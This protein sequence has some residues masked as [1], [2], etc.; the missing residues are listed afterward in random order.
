M[1]TKEIETLIEQ[2]DDEIKES[3]VERPLSADEIESLTSSHDNIP[4]EYADAF[5]A[6]LQNKNFGQFETLPR[7]LRNY[8]GALEVKAL[9]E[10]FGEDLS[11]EPPEVGEYLEQNVMNAA[12]RAGISAEKNKPETKERAKALDTYM[13]GALMRNTMMPTSAAQ[14]GVLYDYREADEVDRIVEQNNA[15]QV[16]M[17]K[18]MLLAQLGKYDVIEKNGLGGALEVPVYET[19]VHGNRTNFVLPAGADSGQVIDAFMGGEGAKT[20]GL[21]E[22]TAATHYAK[23]RKI[24][25]NG[26]LRSE[27][28]E[29]KTF[30]PFKVFSNQYGMNIA[31]GGVGFKGPDRNVITGSG[32]SGHM[33]MRAEKGDK[34]HCGS[35]L[36]GIEGSEPGKSSYLGNDHGARAKSAK[37]SAF[38]ADKSI[39]GKKT[40]GRQVDLSGIDARDLAELLDTFADKYT[41]LQRNADT[42]EGAD[43]IAAINDMLMGKHMQPEKLIEM[44]G[45]LGMNNEKISDIV[46]QARGGYL[47]KLDAAGITEEEFKQSVRATY[48]QDKACQMA[49]ERFERAGDDLELSVGA[50]K[51]LMLT[52]E[53]RKL[54][55]KIRHPIKN[56]KEYLTI[57][58]LTKKLQKEKEFRP[59]DIVNTFRSNEDTF[60]MNWGEGL[61]YD[62]DTVKFALDNMKAFKVGES[63][64]GEVVKEGAKSVSA[65]A[66]A[67]DEVEQMQEEFAEVQESRDVEKEQ[68]VVG[69]ENEF[70]KSMDLT[71]EII[72]PEQPVLNQT[73]NL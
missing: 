65:R 44:L 13:N 42:K 60:S 49:R 61:C 26:A 12:L 24:G 31:V 51:E 20:A 39:V 3:G 57:R 1:T 19:L 67:E 5:R 70:N 58:S 17:A 41:E 33:Y 21:E 23:R 37:Q 46:A 53:T 48:S 15:R 18:T 73:K 22:R 30:S 72:I 2:Y 62:R 14:K 28:K 6:A 29:E 27:T 50:V 52:H 38:L 11:T 16:V 4:G 10:K 35:L 47:S 7:L 66:Y 9:V 45:T 63:K 25:A 59:A 8:L 54:G 34:K 69:E 64:L 36:I 55:W 68:I 71:D 56:I 40:G 32:E 43:K